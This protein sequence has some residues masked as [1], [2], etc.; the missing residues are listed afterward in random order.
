M[1][2]VNV[3]VVQSRWFMGIFLG[4]AVASLVMAAVSLA[5]WS[6]PAARLRFAGCL[7][8]LVGT[9]LV[10]VVCNVP[11]N[12][13]LAA[14]TPE[15]A[16]AASIWSRYLDEWVTWNHVRTVAGAIAAALFV[17]SMPSPSFG[18]GRADA[19]RKVE[20]RHE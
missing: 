17:L 9:F 18:E 7:L 15:S 13:A 16:D 5:S 20:S 11:R 19:L 10:T 12:D 1:N 2:S 4:T 8:Y 14:V 3:W 6:T